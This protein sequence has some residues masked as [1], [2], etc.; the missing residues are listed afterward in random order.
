MPTIWIFP[1]HLDDAA[2]DRPIAV[3]WLPSIDA[4]AP[5]AAA[6]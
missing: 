1:D 3:K 2:L 4:A 5:L 6:A